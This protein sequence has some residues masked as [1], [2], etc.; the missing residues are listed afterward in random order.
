VDGEHG[1]GLSILFIGV[2][3]LH[4]IVETEIIR[5]FTAYFA[6]IPQNRIVPFSEVF[7]DFL[8]CY[9]WAAIDQGHC[10][11]NEKISHVNLVRFFHWSFQNE[12]LRE[13]KTANERRAYS[14]YRYFISP[15]PELM[16][17]LYPETGNKKSL[18]LTGRRS[19]VREFSGSVKI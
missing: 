11:G 14:L 7:S 16:T 3:G 9:G 1:I 5:A 4:K 2:G 12:K 15:H 17:G 8:G 19:V 18:K 6:D 10:W 13:L